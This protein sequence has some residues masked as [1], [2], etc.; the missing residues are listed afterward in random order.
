[1]HLHRL[2]QRTSPALVLLHGIPGSAGSWTKVADR[3]ASR[4]FILVPDLLG[5]G[6]SSDAEDIHEESP[7]HRSRART[8]GSGC[9]SR[10]GC[11][12]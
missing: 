4:F 7:G 12:P 11:R 10:H 1:M 9:R 2:G 3:L 8:R 6:H 5:F